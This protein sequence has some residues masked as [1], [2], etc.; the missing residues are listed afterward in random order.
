MTYKRSHTRPSQKD[1]G[2]VVYPLNNKSL[3]KALNRI[4]TLIKNKIKFSSYMRKFRK[5]RLQSHKGLMAS[6]YMD[7]YLRISSNIRN[8]FLIYD[9][10]TAPMHLN[11]L[12]YVEN[13]VFFFISVER[14]KF[15]YV[16]QFEQ[17]I[18]HC[19]ELYV[20]SLYSGPLIF[21]YCARKVNKL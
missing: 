17:F 19:Q 14:I 8:P 7:K 21:S 12:I 18:N 6:S 1:L 11:F 10:A 15:F 2:S 5:E 9:F 4:T 13:C 16:L 3:G 20:L